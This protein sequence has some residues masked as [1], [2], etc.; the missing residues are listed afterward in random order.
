MTEP[1]RPAGAGCTRREFLGK[2]S[3]VGGM[4]FFGLAAAGCSDHGRLVGDEGPGGG[5]PPPSGRRYAVPTDGEI[6]I[7]ASQGIAVSRVGSNVY[8]HSTTCTHEECAV[9]RGG[10][11]RGRYFDCPCHSARYAVDGTKLLDPAPRSLDRLGI[12][13]V[14]DVTVRVDP[15]VLLE[16]G[17][18][19]YD[20]LR[21]TLP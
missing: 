8:A 5:S 16:E 7:D 13:L 3:G 11:P 20:L 6:V 1:I 17:E 2:C 9:R 14:D 18:S 10:T 4:L 12:E 21:V 19:G 15:A